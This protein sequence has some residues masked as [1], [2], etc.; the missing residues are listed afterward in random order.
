[1]EPSDRFVFGR[2]LPYRNE[3]AREVQLQISLGDEWMPLGP[4]LATGQ[5]LLCARVCWL[6]ASARVR[7]LDARSGEVL[8]SYDRLGDR[9]DATS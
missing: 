7:A 4:V 1:M 2:L 9:L 8:R 6:P 3:D 5:E